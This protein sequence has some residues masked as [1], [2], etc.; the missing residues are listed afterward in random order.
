MKSQEI[1]SYKKDNVY[2]ERKLSWQQ[3]YKK[4]EVKDAVE[5]MKNFGKFMEDV[6]KLSFYVRKKIKTPYQ[7]LLEKT[8]WQAKDNLVANEIIDYLN[9]LENKRAINLS[10][11]P[12]KKG[13]LKIFLNNNMVK[14]HEVQNVLY[15]IDSGVD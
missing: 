10:K 6:E 12:F 3:K 1:S 4:K 5:A 8:E 15:I 11:L 13:Q 2:H 9:S 14:Y 7:K